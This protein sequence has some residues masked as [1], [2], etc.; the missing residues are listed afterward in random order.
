MHLTIIK[1]DNQV[2][3]DGVFY[4]VDCSELPENFHALQWDGPTNGINGFGEVEWTGRPKPPNTEVINLDGFY[5]FYEAWLVEDYKAKNPQPPA[6]M[7]QTGPQE[8][9]SVVA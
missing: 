6:E 5:P 7:T 4:F 2:G 1:Q 8:G 3:V 9:P